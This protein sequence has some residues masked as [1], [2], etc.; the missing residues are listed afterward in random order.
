M[1]LTFKKNNQWL[2][3]LIF[4][5]CLAVVLLYINFPSEALTNYVKIQA[6]KSNP[7]INID[8][9]KI[10]L[11][12]SP[13]IKIRGLRI[14]LKADPGTP[15]YV[16]EKTSIRVSIFNL[17]KGNPKYYFDSSVNGGSISGFL[18]EKNEV[19]KERVDI[20]IDIEGIKLDE[21]LFIHPPVVPP[22]ASL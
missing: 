15:V 12:L 10:A 11:T 22:V 8:F 6:E 20:T 1:Y 16:S 13:G 7:D 4:A 5:V 18:E 14:S 3:Y 9:D 2:W 17:L 21:N 19:Q